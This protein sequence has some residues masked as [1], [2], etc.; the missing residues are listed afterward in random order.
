MSPIRLN[1]FSKK[2]MTLKHTKDNLINTSGEGDP[3]TQNL[4]CIYDVEYERAMELEI[5][6]I[7]FN[8]IEGFSQLNFNN[9]LYF[10]GTGFSDKTNG[11]Y[12]L[13]YEPN[14]PTKNVTILVNSIQHH[15]FPTMIG[16]KTDQIYVIGGLRSK[17]A[18]YY[19]IKTHR[20]RCL[21]DIDEERFNAMGYS[22]EIQE[23]IY[24]FGGYNSDSSANSTC[25][26]RMDLKSFHV[27]EIINLNFNSSLIAKNS[28]AIF[29]F[30]KEECIY[31]LGGRNILGNVTDEIIE[32]DIK[33]NEVALVDKKLELPSSFFNSG[34]TDLNKNEFFFFDDNSNVHNICRNDFRVKMHKYEDIVL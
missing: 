17:A 12:F 32:Y 31:I 14:N 22:D 3:L 11:S 13:K 23:M 25:I 26:L 9:C 4:I 7:F 24:I 28:S 30:D 1:P 18:E 29:K 27:W 8:N 5:N 33:N 15:F 20:W 21:P 34:G 2:L 16:Y 6:S 10:C 19:N